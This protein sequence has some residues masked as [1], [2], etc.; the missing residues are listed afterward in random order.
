MKV[1]D[2]ADPGERSVHSH[3]HARG[4]TVDRAAELL[5]GQLVRP[6]TV[7]GRAVLP[8]SEVGR[9]NAAELV[10][11]L[12]R[13]HQN[14]SAP[15][16]IVVDGLDEARDEAFRIA[17]ELLGRVAAF[18]SV[19]VSTRPSVRE[20]APQS[21]LE[22]LAPVALLDLDEPAHQESQRAAMRG[23]LERRLAGVFDV[24]NPALVADE[25]VANNG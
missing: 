18:A 14:G 3:I 7:D 21:V 16:V 24:M 10:G 4:L 13:L 11:A 9:R 23:Y 17:E 25:L 1:W 15:P 8:P 22:V 20:Q 5:D 2:H 19:I 6:V 12:Q